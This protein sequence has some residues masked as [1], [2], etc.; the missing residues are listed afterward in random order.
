MRGREECQMESEV[1]LGQVPIWCV[2]NYGGGNIT[3]IWNSIM[4][5]VRVRVWRVRGG[6]EYWLNWI[7]ED[8]FTATR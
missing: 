5:K 4:K 7:A 3:F 1:I 8:H 2:K 6:M